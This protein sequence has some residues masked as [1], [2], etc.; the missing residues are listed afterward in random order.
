MSREQLLLQGE[1]HKRPRISDMRLHVSHGKN[2]SERGDT[3]C[4]RAFA[5]QS[6]RPAVTHLISES[7]DSGRG[8]SWSGPRLFLSRDLERPRVGLGGDSG[9]I[10]YELRSI[11]NVKIF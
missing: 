7:N 6:E 11:N 9:S 4:I 3:I 10:A 2:V 5:N 8:R 1:S